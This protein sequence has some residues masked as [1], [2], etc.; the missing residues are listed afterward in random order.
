M[1]LPYPPTFPF[2]SCTDLGDRCR[3]PA[4]GPWHPAPAAAP[5]LPSRLF[6][7][8]EGKNKGKISPEGLTD[9]SFF[10]VLPARSQVVC[11]NRI[12]REMD[13]E[14]P[15][16]AFSAPR[17]LLELEIPRSRGAGRGLGHLTP[18]K[19][20]NSGFGA[21]QQVKSTELCAKTQHSFSEFMASA[22]PSSED[23]QRLPK[24]AK[25]SNPNQ[26]KIQPSLGGTEK[27]IKCSIF[28]LR[29]RAGVSSILCFNS[30]LALS[31]R[32]LLSRISFRGSTTRFVHYIQ[33]QVNPAE[34]SVTGSPK[35]EFVHSLLSVRFR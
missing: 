7:M 1:D 30:R 21:P 34:F 19:G 13:G 23:C 24:I 9:R 25:I 27:G 16:Y 29:S 11:I 3:R 2:L 14:R 22:P 15:T 33:S 6:R 8:E 4:W 35:T 18:S 28:I 20:P 26:F 32:R 31:F 10:A 12:E 17:F 5:A